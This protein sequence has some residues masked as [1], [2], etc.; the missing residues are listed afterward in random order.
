MREFYKHHRH[1]NFGPGYRKGIVHDENYYSMHVQY[2]FLKYI[3]IYLVSIT[4]VLKPKGH[5]IAI[6][7]LKRKA[8]PFTTTKTCFL[9][10]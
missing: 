10:Y 9:H 7:K 5:C 4:Y 3:K 6:Q 1:N 2:P 8:M